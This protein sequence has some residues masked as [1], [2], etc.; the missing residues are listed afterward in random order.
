MS[1]TLVT[2]TLGMRRSRFDSA[3]G[4][5]GVSP[6][7]IS[8]AARPWSFRISQQLANRRS[9]VGPMFHRLV[10]LS[11]FVFLLGDALDS[12]ARAT[13]Q[14]AECNYSFSSGSGNARLRY[15]VSDRGTIPFAED[16][17]LHETLWGAEGYGICNESPVASYW[18]WDEDVSTNWNAPTLLKLT[19]NTVKIART[20]S[21]GIWTLTQTITHERA[22]QDIKIAMA[23]TNNTSVARVAYL[24][25]YADLDTQS[26][27]NNFS[28]TT[29]S[30]IGWD[31]STPFGPNDQY[32]LELRNTGPTQFGY[33]QGFAR[34][35]NF[36]PNPCNFAGD[37]AG[38]VVLHIDG[39]L[40]LAYVDTIGANKTKTATMIYKGL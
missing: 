20:T 23:L 3:V 2:A 18:D 38:G 30:A 13:P 34:T 27:L 16:S 7:R 12:H 9:K 1:R 5:C 19:V 6:S 25:R 29:N 10:I 22:T 37:S 26:E 15:C 11:I 33:V 36:P 8:A 31:Q 35:T 17:T 40:A 32:G 14:Q 21:D 24:V 28:A 4:S 39:S